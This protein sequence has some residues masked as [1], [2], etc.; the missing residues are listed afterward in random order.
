MR[1]RYLTAVAGTRAELIML[2]SGTICTMSAS[3]SLAQSESPYTVRF[4]ASEVV[5][6]AVV[7]DR[8]HIHIVAQTTFEEVD[9]EITNLTA[10]DFHV[11]ED[12]VERPV[13][14]VSLE[15]PHILDVQDNV[16]RHLE[17]SFT[18][19]GIWSSP[20]LW[21]SSAPRPALHLLPI[22]LVSY[23]PPLS[24]RGSCHR[25]QVKVKRRHATVYARDEYC[26]VRHSP[27]DPLAGTD[28]GQQMERFAH[29]RDYGQFPVSL[30]VGS[31]T[32]NSDE[33]RTDVAV[34]FPWIAIKREWHHVNLRAMVAI[35]GVLS[36]KN[37]DTVARFSDI[38]TTLPWNFYRGPLPPDRNL[39]KIWEVAAIPTRYETQL[40]LPSGDYDLHLVVTD[41]E[42]F[43]RVD[44]PVHVDGQHAGLAL[45][46]PILCDRFHEVLEGMR[47]A[48]RAPRYVPLVVEGREF[49]PVA[50]TRFIQRQSLISYFELHQADTA[51]SAR[52][53][54]RL[55]SMERDELRIDTGW[56]TVEIG[57][58]PGTRAMPVIAE[59]STDDLSPGNYSLQIE[60]S[61]STG[62]NTTQHL[63]FFAIQESSRLPT[64]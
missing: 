46:H 48:A 60:A 23:E 35:L 62:H 39:L 13:H 6:P 5:V 43:G 17:Y 11:F 2:L 15:L 53:R 27:S 40:E 38:A 64:P 54:I 49:T 25:I 32:N 63:T 14:N 9:E 61:D 36:A 34:K 10:G 45:S 51:H 59:L 21:P 31:L 44:V 55:R 41:G 57:F 3:R 50:D 24:S 42:E 22:Y 20:D 58:R 56:Q 16:S 28:L 29:S 18:P 52:L 37:G 47:A 12:G 4:E 1:L 7:L 8:T 26:N 19:A 33:T 30:Q